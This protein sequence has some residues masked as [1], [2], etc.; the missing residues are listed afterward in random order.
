MPAGAASALLHD[1]VTGS[2]A[3]VVAL[4]GTENPPGTPWRL[5]SIGAA[6]KSPTSFETQYCEDG[7]KCVSQVSTFGLKHDG[8]YQSS[9][10]L[11]QERE[12][13]YADAYE[14]GCPAKGT[15]N[16]SSGECEEGDAQDV[17]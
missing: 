16:N 13:E 10:K 5:A 3:N 12:G 11:N 14:W 7:F 15:M 4:P 8:K 2:T 9:D 6:W 1:L 17:Q